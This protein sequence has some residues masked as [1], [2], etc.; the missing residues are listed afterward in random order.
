MYATLPDSNVF[1][2]ANWKV[3]RGVW[4]TRVPPLGL[5][6]VDVVG[7]LARRGWKAGGGVG[8]GGSGLH[9]R[10]GRGRPSPCFVRIGWLA[11]ELSEVRA[12]GPLLRAGGGVGLSWSAEWEVLGRVGESVPIGRRA[13]RAPRA[14][15][16]S[17]GVKGASG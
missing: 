11:E 12:G 7:S 4:T 10:G 17:C 15:G 8:A 1:D 6:P 13:Y 14:E 5:R 2:G 16:L 3:R 9:L